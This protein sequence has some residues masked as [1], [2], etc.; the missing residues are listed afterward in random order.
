MVAEE[1]RAVRSADE[2]RAVAYDRAK[3]EP[4]V[5]NAVP[6][7]DEAYLSEG[8]YPYAAPAVLKTV[9]ESQ[10]LFYLVGYDRAVF[11]FPRGY[12]LGRCGGAISPVLFARVSTSFS[13][14]RVFFIGAVLLFDLCHDHMAFYPAEIVIFLGNVAL[15]GIRRESAVLAGNDVG[16]LVPFADCE[17]L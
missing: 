9:R 13:S 7:L 2:I 5:G 12:I 1:K 16:I 14:S 6:A 17:P 10:E 4:A 11:A 3:V 15:C 8:A